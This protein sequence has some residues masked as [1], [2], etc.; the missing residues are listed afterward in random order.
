[1]KVSKMTLK[2]LKCFRVVS[3]PAMLTAD[4]Q[5]G[6]CFG[7]RS[8]SRIAARGIWRLWLAAVKK[9]DFTGIDCYCGNAALINDSRVSG[10]LGC[11]SSLLHASFST[12]L[13]DSWAFQFDLRQGY[14]SITR[15][16]A[17]LWW[18][19]HY[20]ACFET[21]KWPGLCSSISSRMLNLIFLPDI[22]SAWQV[23]QS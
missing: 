19:M 23:C 9:R 13:V 3:V 21:W 7:C 22:S 2:C 12:A 8:V 6:A 16:A 5:T 11:W 20:F 15:K 18:K 4:C 17:L 10:N 1:M 14:Q